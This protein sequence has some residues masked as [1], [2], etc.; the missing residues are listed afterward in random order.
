MRIDININGLGT[1]SSKTK[2]VKK[3]NFERIVDKHVKSF[4]AKS[5]AGIGWEAVNTVV[6]SDI[7]SMRNDVTAQAKVDNTISILNRGK[8]IAE[9]A[10]IG[11][12]YG[13]WGA[14]IGMAIGA[15]SQL[16][17]AY[18]ANTEWKLQALENKINSN[19]ELEALGMTATDLNR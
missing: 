10:Y 12:A 15:A 1:K 18:Q 8:N 17:H 4:S 19:I 13:P 5:I 3:T 6:L 16:I 9:A 7:G 2:T 14:V 11:G